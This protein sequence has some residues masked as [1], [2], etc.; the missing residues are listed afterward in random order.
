MFIGV[1]IRYVCPRIVDFW[2]TSKWVP[3]L[4]KGSG[5]YAAGLVALNSIF[6]VLFYSVYFRKE[7]LV[8]SGPR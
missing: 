6:Q 4:A 2:G 8:L 7:C 5:E 1:C 3:N